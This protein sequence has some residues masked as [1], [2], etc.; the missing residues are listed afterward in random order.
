MANKLTQSWSGWLRTLQPGDLLDPANESRVKTIPEGLMKHLQHQAKDL[1]AN[2][3][4]APEDIRRHW[5]SVVEGTPPFGLLLERR[6]KRK[7]TVYAERI[8]KTDNQA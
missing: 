1:L 5:Q 8:R 6:T 3:P 4:N 7:G 2:H